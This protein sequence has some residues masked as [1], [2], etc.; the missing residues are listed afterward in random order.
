MKDLMGENNAIIDQDDD[1]D[2][3]DDDDD[4]Y[5]DDED[6][7][8][9]GYEDDDDDDDDD[10]ASYAIYVDNN[11]NDYDDNYI[12]SGEAVLPAEYGGTNGTVDEHRLAGRGG[13]E[14]AGG[15]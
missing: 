10:D 4:E 9:G 14:G 6:D 7:D 11:A 8:D 13:G 1:D 5:G 3:G 15:G 2:D 12:F